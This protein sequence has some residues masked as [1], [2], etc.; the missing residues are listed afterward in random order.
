MVENVLLIGDLSTVY[1][2]NAFWIWKQSLQSPEDL[3]AKVIVINNGGGRI[4]RRLFEN[5]AL[6]SEHNLEFSDL[7][8]VF[9]WEYFR[10]THSSQMNWEGLPNQCLV[11]LQPNLEDSDSAI[12]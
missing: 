1:D 5:P 7:A 6:Q 8:Q 3:P 4:F 9:G 12:G 10:W 2:A 11:E